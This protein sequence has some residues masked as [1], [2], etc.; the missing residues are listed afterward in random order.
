[1]V[2]TVK[3]YNKDLNN[4][5]GILESGKEVEF[6]PFVGGGISMTDNQYFNN[7]GFSIV[8]KKYKLNDNVFISDD[9]MICPSETE[10]QEI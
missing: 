10:I 4:C 5:I 7:Y 8:G 2:I 1:M 9:G 6:D 3:T